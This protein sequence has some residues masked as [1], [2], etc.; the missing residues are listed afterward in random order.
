MPVVAEECVCVPNGAVLK[1][2]PHKGMTER[3]E[4][5]VHKRLFILM[6]WYWREVKMDCN[7]DYCRHHRGEGGRPLLMCTQDW[8]ALSSEMRIAI[9]E[10]VSD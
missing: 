5:P 6:G 3:I 8:N 1:V 10:S 4:C 2:W 7:C 9:G